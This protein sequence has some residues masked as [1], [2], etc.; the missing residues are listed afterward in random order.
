M[1]CPILSPKGYLDQFPNYLTQILK[2][3]ANGDNEDL[4]S[5][6]C[7]LQIPTDP[8]TGCFVSL[9]E[10]GRI[11]A[12]PFCCNYTAINPL[13]M[14]SGGYQYYQLRL[15]LNQMMKLYW[16]TKKAKYLT[17]SNACCPEIPSIGCGAPVYDAED[18]ENRVCLGHGLQVFTVGS[19]NDYT[20]KC[21]E[22]SGGGYFAIFLPDELN[23][24]A[25]YMHK[26][27]DEC[28]FYPKMGALFGSCQSTIQNY[29]PSRG[30]N[31][32]IELIIS[33]LGA[34]EDT[35]YIN[36]YQPGGDCTCGGLDE[37]PCVELNPIKLGIELFS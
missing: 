18:K 29:Y 7:K 17:Y 34:E 8:D 14:M 2:N 37:F 20:K 31:G 5:C 4:K 13:G 1:S 22:G 33:A 3:I 9:D 32:K 16:N 28:Y 21:N 24:P 19:V 27:G 15:T 11:G 26:E 10:D 12:F 35:L 23:T 30:P 25:C 36:T 6:A